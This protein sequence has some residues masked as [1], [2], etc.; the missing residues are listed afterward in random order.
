M[1]PNVTW[2]IPEYKAHQ[3][4]WEICNSVYDGIDTAIAYLTQKS[5]E[6]NDIF[7]TR[8]DNATLNNFIERINTSM[9][10]EIFRK[11]LT[12]EKVPANTLEKLKTIAGTKNLDQFTKIV[13]N[14]AIL[15]GKAYIL[16]DAPTNG[17][18]PYMSLITRE[19]L[20]NYKKDE[21]GN[22]TFAVIAESY[23]ESLDEF[24]YEVKPQYRV[25]DANGN[26]RIFRSGDGK[27]AWYVFEEINTTYNF[28]PLYELKISDIPPLYDIAKVNVQHMNYTSNQSDYVTEAMC[29]ILFGKALGVEG[30][31]NV[32][33][34]GESPE[35]QIV[36]GIR[37]A[38]FAE[39]PE[40]DLSWI[41]LQAQGNYEISAKHIDKLEKDMT[42]R[43]LSLQE[44]SESKSATQVSSEDVEADSRL[45]DIAANTENVIN[46]ALEGWAAIGN[47]T[48]P[49]KM[50]VNRDFN[51]ITVGDITG[52]NTLQVS[53][54]L[55]RETLLKSLVKNEVIDLDSVDEELKR[56]EEENVNSLS[57]ET[58]D[59]G[60]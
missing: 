2:K 44:S 53:G 45:T 10:G 8:Q 39:N 59:A 3:H 29:P 17:G 33:G 5:Y 38:S 23:T 16:V 31:D 22:F 18:D 36:L 9:T 35:P 58:E 48:F 30:E 51:E 50:I 46:N 13:T 6:Y 55:S 42:S 11:P 60:V 34:E 57:L 4:Q 52:L 49:G 1:T 15:N 25:I 54:N 19:Q 28:C 7:A 47:T 24:S 12:A 27:S 32:L 20:I 37:N 41:E 43:A 21:Q 14:S 56:I 40:A 26:V